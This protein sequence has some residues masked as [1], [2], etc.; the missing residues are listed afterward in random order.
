MK[1]FSALLTLLFVISLTALAQSDEVPSASLSDIKEVQ[2]VFI[3]TGGNVTARDIIAKEL[4]AA[5]LGIQIVDKPEDADTILRFNGA[6]V[7]IEKTRQNPVNAARLRP[8]RR[9][10]EP[11]LMALEP[12]EASTG[13]STMPAP[14]E[15]VVIIK[16]KDGSKVATTPSLE[17]APAR[18]TEKQ[19][20]SKVPST[21]PKQFAASF[22]QLYKAAKEKQ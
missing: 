12:G 9:R 3:D 16:K 13:V 8:A 15:G 18:I 22:I 4:E 17:T 1:R 14:G 10:R 5:D 19:V 6:H 21:P 7:S 11:P 2:K 20:K